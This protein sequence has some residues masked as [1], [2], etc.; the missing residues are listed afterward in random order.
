M[1]I[2]KLEEK[3]AEVTSN[4][5]A[6][7]ASLVALQK[8]IDHHQK[9]LET[10]TSS[11]TANKPYWTKTIAS[12]EMNHHARFIYGGFR[13]TSEQENNVVFGRV[14][15][16]T[17]RRKIVIIDEGESRRPPAVS[18]IRLTSKPLWNKI[19]Y[20]ASTT[21]SVARTGEKISYWSSGYTT[22]QYQEDVEYTNAH[23]D[24]SHEHFP[25]KYTLWNPLG[26]FIGLASYCGGAVLGASTVASTAI[27]DG[28]TLMDSYNTQPRYRTYGRFTKIT[29]GHQ[30]IVLDTPEWSS[31]CSNEFSSAIIN[32]NDPSE[33][34][35]CS[36]EAEAPFGDWNSRYLTV[37][38]YVAYCDMPEA[39]KESQQLQQKIMTLEQERVQLTDALQSNIQEKQ[40]IEAA[41]SLY[42]S[43]AS[44]NST[45]FYDRTIGLQSAFSAVT[46][47]QYMVDTVSDQRA[48]ISLN[49]SI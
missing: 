44:V 13:N 34:S 20:A 36:I 33:R 29:I 28:C 3:L 49:G 10:I 45:L 22:A 46:S 37:E 11:E 38:V 23:A 8:K 7:E 14:E 17:F 2:Q 9:Q 1:T 39:Q 19:T 21:S 24:P 6:I 25:R 30:E 40:K 42:K 16:S 32:V 15:R 26:H 27:M 18:R 41:I 12:G 4:K 47:S 48:T 43:P 5:T 35:I 31:E